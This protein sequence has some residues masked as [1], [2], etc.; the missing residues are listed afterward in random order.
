MCVSGKYNVL[1]KRFWYDTSE[2]CQ[3]QRASSYLMREMNFISERGQGLENERVI[4]GRELNIAKGTTD[5][6]I[7][8]I[9]PK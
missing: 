7:E 9:L 6:R 1:G 2:T 4:Q 8:F 3:G 5:P